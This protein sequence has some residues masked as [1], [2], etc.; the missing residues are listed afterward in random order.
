MKTA[1]K[2]L[3]ALA[4]GHA[5]CSST[6]YA[7]AGTAIATTIFIDE[8]GTESYKAVMADEVIV[9]NGAK[10]TNIVGATTY[11]GQDIKNTPTANKTIAEIIASHSN[12]QLANNSRDA[13]TQGEIHAQDF[14]I[15]GG[16]Y[17]DNKIMFN[18]VNIA[19][20][21]NPVGANNSFADNSLPASAQNATI[22][23]E[24]LCEIQVLDSNVLAEHGNFMGGA[25][26][27]KTCTPESETGKLHGKIIHD[28][29]TSDWVKYNYS[30]QSEMEQ[31]EENNNIKYQKEYKKQGLSGSFYGRVSDDLGINLSLS[32]RDSDIYQKANLPDARPYTQ[33]RKA[34]NIMLGF[35]YDIDDE[36]SVRLNIS[37]TNAYSLLYQPNVAGSLHEIS[38][39]GQAI[40]LSFRHILPKAT[41]TH[42]LTYQQNKQERSV[43][44]DEYL[45]WR[46]SSAKNWGNGSTSPEGMTGTPLQYN[47]KSFNYQIKTSLDKVEKSG[48]GYQFSAGMEL[49]KDHVNWYRPTDYY[50]YFTPAIAG[51]G[52]TNCQRSDGTID[53]YCDPTYERNGRIVGQFHTKRTYYQAGEIDLNYI[54]WS[55]Y[56]NHAF[57]YKSYLSTNLGL[58]Y[59]DDNL[60]K[61]S[62]L[63]PRFNATY[64]PF[65]NKT[66]GLTVG[67]NRY[68]GRN[69]FNLALQDG[70]NKFGWEQ[71]RTNLNS[72]WITQGNSTSTNVARSE[73]KT[74]FSNE[75]VVGL[76]GELHNAD[77]Q[78]KYVHRKNKDQI[79]R[80]RVSANPL[81]T[82]YDN[83]GRSE[84]NVYSLS[85]KN[86]YPI[87]LLGGQHQ[88]SLG[89]GYR[90]VK[91]NFNDYDDSVANEEKY[92][93]YDG[94]V[95]DY[96]EI[97]TQSFNQPWTAN[98]GLHSSF[99]NFSL[100][101]Q[102][103]YRSSN[104]NMSYTTLPLSDQFVHDGY[105]VR[106]VYDKNK[107]GGKF[108]WDLNFEY[109]IGKDKQ[110]I[111]GGTINN[112]LNRKSQ[113]LSGG[114]SRAEKGR[115]FLTQI[116]F[117]F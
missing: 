98:L 25:V 107:L 30:S 35:D 31:F 81:V 65:G 85:I 33:E 76:S 112:V 50:W 28:Y 79:R 48:F 49:G 13:G 89:M 55:A 115:E 14:S 54:H 11:G 56:M 1:Q 12:V 45:T 39:I 97:P 116:S 3:L 9:L 73:L 86:K 101:H 63:S 75:Y 117:K 83:L 88:L 94:K 21:I 99:N 74:P 51:A 23:T 26:L 46:S 105:T 40:D 18:N 90:E 7:N 68:Y 4:V 53:R 58:R 91:R 52:G 15:N 87:N 113:Y 19:N 47:K 44:A 93:L 41:L 42:A 17:Y 103:S 84:A 57:D 27:A 104:Y 109:A 29:A 70:I 69:A 114:T 111:L 59:D 110:V 8:T 22:N 72:D 37:H 66:L 34:D 78:L 102:F 95:I 67:A 2:T 96:T 10:R 61:N 82:S 24:L 16:L 60:S 77:W 80:Y 108:I 92:V 38:D 36:N 64:Y 6:A 20:Q 43:E 71:T 106:R 32:R 100:N 62:S 5:L